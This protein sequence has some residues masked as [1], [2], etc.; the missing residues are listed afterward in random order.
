MKKIEIEADD[1][2]KEAREIAEQ[3]KKKN[4][5]SDKGDKKNERH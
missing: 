3:L 4:Q 5:S 1:F 2:Y